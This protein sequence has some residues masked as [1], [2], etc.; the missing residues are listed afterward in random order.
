[1]PKYKKEINRIVNKEDAENM[2]NNVSRL[3]DKFIIAI[4][5]LTGARPS[6][7]IEL[8]KKDILS[9]RG[10]IL[11]RLSTKKLGKSNKFTLEKRVLEINKSAPFIDII[12]RYLDRFNDEDF[13]INVS[14]TR[15]WQIIDKASNGEM[16]P[17]NF[18]HSR[19]T[20]LARLGAS[21]DELMYWKGAK[22]IKSVAPYLRAKPIGRKFSIE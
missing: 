7:I 6:E 13:L 11:I 10:Y 16:T 8:K 17:Y 18:R 1:M 3:R 19:L 22:S 4:H 20:K 5:Y 2:I 9:T 14:Y 21:V 15:V 12:L